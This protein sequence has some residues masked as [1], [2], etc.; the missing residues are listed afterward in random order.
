MFNQ[1]TDP[2]AK[3]EVVRLRVPKADDKK[4]DLFPL[5]HVVLRCEEFG[6][7]SYKEFKYRLSQKGTH[8]TKLIKPA[9]ASLPQSFETT[10]KIVTVLDPLLEGLGYSV[11]GRNKGE[12][13]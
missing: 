10:L 2:D 12:S 3:F 9:E 6:I 13:C 1:A 4:E 8:M 5:V 11:Q 7:V